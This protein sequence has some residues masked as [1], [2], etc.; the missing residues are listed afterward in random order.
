MHHYTKMQLGNQRV[1]PMST[2]PL[3]GGV[4][5]ADQQPRIFNYLGDTP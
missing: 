5:K 1:E 2:N 3:Y 4:Y